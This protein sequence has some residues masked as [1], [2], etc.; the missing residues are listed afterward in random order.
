M[1]ACLSDASE[2][3]PRNSIQWSSWRTVTASKRV[4]PLSGIRILQY[5]IR[6]IL[7][8][9]TVRASRQ[10]RR[11]GAPAV[12][13]SETVELIRLGKRQDCG[14]MQQ[15]DSSHR[16]PLARKSDHPHHRD[17]TGHGSTI[18]MTGHTPPNRL[19]CHSTGS[20]FVC[21]SAHHRVRWA[22]G[23]DSI[24]TVDFQVLLLLTLLFSVDR[25]S[26]IRL[27]VPTSFTR[28]SRTSRLQLCTET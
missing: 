24:S 19:V 25:I 18:C 11:H 26:F 2:Q 15:T 16:T 14:A 1:Q 7:Y 22:R 17:V 27:L 9:R 20:E 5:T 8:M 28:V 10:S 23:G 21:L 3:N 12:R 13:R 4:Q 6:R